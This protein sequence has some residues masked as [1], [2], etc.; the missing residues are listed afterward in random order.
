MGSVCQYI[1]YRIGMQHILTY[2]YTLPTNIILIGEA[3]NVQIEIEND[4]CIGFA[5]ENYL[6]PRNGTAQSSSI[7]LVKSINYSIC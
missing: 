7:K 5:S 6:N 1:V 3:N 2:I 4:V